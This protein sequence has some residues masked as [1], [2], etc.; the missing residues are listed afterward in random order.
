MNETK[1][2]SLLACQRRYYASGATLSYASRMHGP[3]LLKD[4]IEHH[5]KDL[6]ARNTVILKP[7]AYAPASSEILKNAA[8]QSLIFKA[9]RTGTYGFPIPTENL[10]PAC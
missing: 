7:S 2:Q 9:K 6:A 10:K 1:L 4:A 3:K 5:E 8:Q